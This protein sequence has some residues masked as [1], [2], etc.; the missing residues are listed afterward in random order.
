M[1][2]QELKIVG[3]GVR[4]KDAMALLL[5]KPA[6]VDDVV[7]YDSQ[8][9]FPETG[10]D[11]KIYIAKDTNLT[12]RWSGSQYVEISPSIALGETS[13]TAYRGDRGKA[14]YDH[15]QITSGNPHGTTADDVGAA[16]KSHVSVKA[17]A[18]GLGHVKAGGEFSVAED[19]TLN[20][21]TVDG[22]TF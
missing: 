15:S 12:Y 21:A 3:K 9:D 7:E 17:S 2:Q 11:G 1:D 10:E 4:K 19:G 6:Y 22:G 16:P 18:A 8:D 14:A 5:G 20:L 13:S